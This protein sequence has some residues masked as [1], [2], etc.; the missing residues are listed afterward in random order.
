MSLISKGRRVVFSSLLAASLGLTGLWEYSSPGRVDPRG[1]QLA[2][3]VN[4]LHQR[5][6]RLKVVPSRRD[7]Q[8]CDN[9]YLTQDPALTWQS[10]QLKPRTADALGQWRGSVWVGHFSLDGVDWRLLDCPEHACRIGDFLLF[11][12]HQL[13]ERIQQTFLSGGTERCTGLP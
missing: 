2:D 6:L 4:H 11:G 3:L 10:F 5:G 13:I 7:G 8:W 1:R 12:D 9:V